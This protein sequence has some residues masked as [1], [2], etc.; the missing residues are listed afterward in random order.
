M[1]CDSPAAKAIKARE[2]V[3][4]YPTIKFFPKG[5]TTAQ[6]YDGGRTVAELVS[7]VNDKAGTHRLPGGGLDAL[8]GTIPSL[9]T[10]VATLKSGGEEAYKNLESAAAALKDKYAEYYGKVAK[11]A[12]AN[13]AYIDKELARLQGLLKK[14]GMAS[15]KIDDLTSRSNILRKF[16]G[17]ES[18]KDEL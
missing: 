2:D 17:E 10:I 12:E 9:D 15:E 7:F 3:S 1:D 4:S 16:K 5:S 14:G 11:K 6:S 13:S 8:A 18:F